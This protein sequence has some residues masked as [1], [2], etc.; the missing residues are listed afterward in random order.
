MQGSRP[1]SFSLFPFQG[2]QDW[3]Y[4]MKVYLAVNLLVFL[5]TVSSMTALCALLLIGVAGL[6]SVGYAVSGLSVLAFLVNYNFGLTFP[7]PFFGL[8]KWV[9]FGA[10][11]G[12]ILLAAIGRGVFFN[13][14]TYALLAFSATAIPGVLMTELKLVSAMKLCIFTFGALALLNAYRVLTQKDQKVVAVTLLSLVL[15]LLVLSAMVYP[16]PSIKYF[17]ANEHSFLMFGYYAQVSYYQGALQHSQQLGPVC[18]LI[19][20]GVSTLYMYTR[21]HAIVYLPIICSCFGFIFLTKS[22]TALVSAVVGLIVALL[23]NQL[24]GC[25]GSL[26]RIA[27]PFMHSR[28][29]ATHVV[30]AFMGGLLIVLTAFPYVSKFATRFLFKTGQS[31]SGGTLLDVVASRFERVMTSL[32]YFQTNPIFGTGFG[33]SIN[34][35]WVAQN[36]D[37]LFSAPVEKAF[38]LT[39]VLE[40]V[41]ILGFCF[42]S[43]LCVV[44]VRSWFREGRHVMLAMF[45]TFL[46]V[47]FGEMAFFSFGGIGMLYWALVLFMQPI[48][49]WSNEPFR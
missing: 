26:R 24:R 7:P 38:I 25:I 40:E 34:P 23:L 10:L 31:F 2:K 16:F 21:R 15:L 32:Q 1:E 29:L 6:T 30:G 48:N 43:I 22:R 17:R 5:Y 20:C 36:R 46:V 41:G 12:R 8:L 3:I 14:I 45:L 27:I 33:V 9:L 35:R 19:I 13:P 18:A 28:L 44:I 49:D 4:L 39:G 42:F 11:C 37:S 47:N